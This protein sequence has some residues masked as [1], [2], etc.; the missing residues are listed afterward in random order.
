MIG[1]VS[2]SDGR[3]EALA[4]AME[5]FVASGVEFVVHCGDVGGRHVLDVLAR[6]HSGFVWGDRDA[7]RMGLLRYAQSQGVTC[8][9]SMGEFDVGERRLV[10]V[11]GEDKKLI[12]RLLDEQQYDYILCGHAMAAEDRTVGRTRVLNPGPLYGPGTARSAALLDPQAGKLRLV[13]L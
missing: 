4:A 2:N 1:V 6:V 8:F 12:A 9:G 5:V 7:D 10:V 3:A 13:P 11:H